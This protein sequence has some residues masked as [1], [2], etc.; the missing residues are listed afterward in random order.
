MDEPGLATPPVAGTGIR[1]SLLHAVCLRML[2]EA[3]PG[4]RPAWLRDFV[5]RHPL[6][7]H[8]GERPV[9]EPGEQE[10]VIRDEFAS[11]CGG[12]LAELV[13]LRV[14]EEE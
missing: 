5:T 8:A 12:R 10:A 3:D 7:L 11:F 9:T 2:T 4:A 13:R 14:V 6:R 1:I